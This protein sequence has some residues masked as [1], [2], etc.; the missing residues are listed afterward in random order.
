[1][2]FWAFWWRYFLR[3][4]WTFC[5]FWWI[6]A[7]TFLG[8]HH[9]G[10]AHEGVEFSLNMQRKCSLYDA[11]ILSLLR[12]SSGSI[13]RDAHSPPY[14][15]VHLL[16][17]RLSK[18]PPSQLLHPHRWRHR[19][20]L[21]PRS[22]TS[23]PIV[24][25]LPRKFWHFVLSDRSPESIK[26]ENFIP[27]MSILRCSDSGEGSRSSFASINASFVRRFSPIISWKQSTVKLVEDRQADRRTD[28]HQY[29]AGRQKT[30]WQQRDC[31][32]TDR[33]TDKFSW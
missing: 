22:L 14:P 17:A 9:G 18:Q 11:F 5:F 3:H 31:G 26:R 20:G 32:Q 16:G 24:S 23:Q 12:I 2:I 15:V 21:I 30:D 4:L 27:L 8:F 7:R 28:K 25:C 6:A 1:M 10:V 19:H 29:Q 13:L 33:K